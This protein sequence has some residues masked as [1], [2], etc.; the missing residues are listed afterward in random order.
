MRFDAVAAVPMLGPAGHPEQGRFRVDSGLSSEATT[1][2]K[3]DSTMPITYE[4]DHGLKVGE[5]TAFLGIEAR[6]SECGASH[7]NAPP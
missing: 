3:G 4:V 5:A 6:S 7:G 2:G 1:A